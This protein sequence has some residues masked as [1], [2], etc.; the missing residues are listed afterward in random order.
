MKFLAL[1]TGLLALNIALWALGHPFRPQHLQNQSFM[2][3]ALLLWVCESAICILSFCS[4]GVLWA[5][6][7]IRKAPSNVRARAVL[8]F[9]T[10]LV[11]VSVV[12]L[13]LITLQLFI[14]SLG[15]R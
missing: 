1:G 10:A 15:A 5:W 12:M 13:V 8:L 4:A 11:P 7:K 2:M 9:G 3:P 6:G 14:S